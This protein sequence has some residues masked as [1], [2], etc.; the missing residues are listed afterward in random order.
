MGNITVPHQPGPQMAPNGLHP[1]MLHQKVHWLH[2]KV[3]W[4]IHRKVHTPEG[5]PRQGS[6]VDTGQQPDGQRSGVALVLQLDPAQHQAAQA[7]ASA[8]AGCRADQAVQEE[9][10]LVQVQVAKD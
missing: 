9:E 1:M 7:E 4:W 10:V 8:Q 5:S 3:H 2:Q 6:V